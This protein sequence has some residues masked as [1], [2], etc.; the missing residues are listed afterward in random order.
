MA[1]L[2]KEI[3]S[4]PSTNNSLTS[5]ELNTRHL[6]KYDLLRYIQTPTLEFS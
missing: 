5:I 1:S 6:N 3:V 4:K 2:K